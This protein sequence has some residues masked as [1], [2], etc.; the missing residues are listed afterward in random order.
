MVIK[1]SLVEDSL[2]VRFYER[3]R[4]QDLEAAPILS[5]SRQMRVIKEKEGD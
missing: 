2:R 4:N 5:P 3:L 1:N